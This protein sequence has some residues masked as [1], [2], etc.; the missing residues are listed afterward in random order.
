MPEVSIRWGAMLT[1]LKVRSARATL[2]VAT[3]F[4]LFGATLVGFPVTNASA[5]THAVVDCGLVNTMSG[6]PTTMMMLGNTSCIVQAARTGKPA[7]YVIRSASSVTSKRKTFDG[8]PIPEPIITTYL[9]LGN[10]KVKVTT[11]QRAAGG[12][13]TSQFCRGLRSGGTYPSSPSLIGPCHH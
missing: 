1:H 9:V 12:K 10:H 13:L 6:W 3:L 4:S 7:R 2:I 11:D 5:A 8:Y